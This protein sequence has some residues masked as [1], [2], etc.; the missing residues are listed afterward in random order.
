M[1][2][3]DEVSLEIKKYLKNLARVISQE[4]SFT[5]FKVKIVEKKR[6]DDILCCVDA[7]FPDEYKAY[8]KKYGIKSLRTAG[9]YRQLQDCIRRKF[10]L[11][12][13]SYAV[14]YNDA[15]GL[16]SMISTSIDLDF[17]RLFNSESSMF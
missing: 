7:T 6:I 15:I 4:A 17:K 13:E 12:P 10:W 2:N 11:N 8:V 9:Q 3:P 5:F 1:L 16:I 14:L